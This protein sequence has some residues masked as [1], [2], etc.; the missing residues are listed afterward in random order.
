MAKVCNVP[1][2]PTIS[3]TPRCPA[4]MLAAERTRGSAHQR[5]YGT[6][7]QRTRRRYLRANPICCEP[8]CL[9]LATDVD[10]ID[11]LGPLGPNGHN[12]DNLRAYCHSHHSQ[13]TARDSPGGWAAMN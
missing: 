4:H 10:H 9:R 12:P 11:A 13:R 3:D 6:K 8:D 2:C 7:W 5:G 1:G